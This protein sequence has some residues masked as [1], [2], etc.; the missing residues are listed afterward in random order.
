MQGLAV[1]RHM[2]YSLTRAINLYL[3]A[4]RSYQCDLQM[5]GS[6]VQVSK[7]D[8]LIACVSLLCFTSAWVGRGTGDGMTASVIALI[9]GQ[10]E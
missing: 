2:M 10:W 3:T 4:H 6:N 9:I 8:V 5:E 1:V 7:A